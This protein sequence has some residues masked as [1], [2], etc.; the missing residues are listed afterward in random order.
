MQPDRYPDE[1]RPNPYPNDPA[2]PQPGPY[3]NDPTYPQ[4]NTYPNTPPY[5]QPTEGYPQGNPYQ[6]G[7]QSTQPP[8]QG[9]SYQ[10]TPRDQRPPNGARYV[11]AKIIDYITWAI[12]VL[13]VI[14]LLRFFL[15]LV[16]ADPNNAFAQFLYNLTGFFLYPFAGIVPSGKFGI[17]VTH[18]FEWSTLIGM[19]V[20]GLLFWILKYFLRTA[21]SSPEEPIY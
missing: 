20:Y 16:G 5:A 14:F 12:L 2:Y 4:P 1:S 21:I 11:V 3:P 19:L 13:E 17:N 10:Q 8:Y 6:Q 18:V 15:K 9:H 7:W